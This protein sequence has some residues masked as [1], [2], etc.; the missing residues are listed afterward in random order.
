[1]TLKGCSDEVK[2]VFIKRVK[3]GRKKKKTNTKKMKR[4]MWLFNTMA[5]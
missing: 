1:L 5:K 4:I 3:Y 2:G